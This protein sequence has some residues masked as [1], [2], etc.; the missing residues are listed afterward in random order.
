M[1]STR[2]IVSGSDRKMDGKTLLYAGLVVLAVVVILAVVVLLQRPKG[3][4]EQPSALPEG[5]MAVT[6]ELFERAIPA[7]QLILTGDIVKIIGI[8]KKDMVYPMELEY[9]EVLHVTGRESPQGLTVQLALSQR[10]ME[11]LYAIRQ[12]YQI[13]VAII[14]RGDPEQA[15]QL[16]AQQDEM[17]RELQEEEKAAA[18]KA[19]EEKAA[20]EKA[21]AEKAAAEKAAGK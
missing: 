6:Q 7:D 10:Q 2:E 1:K 15:Q 8:G 14:S 21:A 4:E 13:T 9:V 17:I 16:L 11:R 20:A 12:N 19:A 18:E 3:A 5:R